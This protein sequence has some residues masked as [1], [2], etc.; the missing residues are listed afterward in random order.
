MWLEDAD[1]FAMIFMAIGKFSKWTRIEEICWYLTSS[2]CVHARARVWNQP[3]PVTFILDVWSLWMA[4]GNCGLCKVSIEPWGSLRCDIVMTLLIASILI[5]TYDWV[6]P[7][8]VAFIIQVSTPTD[9]AYRS[10][11]CHTLCLL[12]NWWPWTESM[13]ELSLLSLTRNFSLVSWL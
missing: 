2:Q 1:E 9:V 7:W 4:C 10:T 5:Q 13:F 12:W 11:N 3:S 6:F 8:F